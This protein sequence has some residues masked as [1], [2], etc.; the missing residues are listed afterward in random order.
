MFQTR[1][2]ISLFI[3][4][5]V[6]LLLLNGCTSLGSGNVPTDRFNYN[7]AIAKSRN[8]QML[9]NI[10]RAR[11]LDIPDFL[12]VSSVIT[13][14]SYEG[15]LGV[16]GTTG[17]LAATDNIY[18]GNINLGYAAKPTISYAP[19]SGQEFNRRMVKEIP[20]E[21]LF[22]LGHAGWPMDILM[23]ISISRINHIQNMGFSQVPAPG[24]VP[25]AEKLPYE[26]QH[27]ENFQSLL[28]LILRLEESGAMEVQRNLKDGAYQTYLH[29]HSN[30]SP[31]LQPMIRKFK[32]QLELDET[33]NN[34]RITGRITDI[35][36]D[37]ITMQS[38]SLLAIISYL[39]HGIEVPEEDSNRGLVVQL[40]PELQNAMFRRLPLRVYSQKEKPEDPYVAVRYRGYWFYIDHSDIRSKRTFSTVQVL[41]QLQAPSAASAAPVLTLPTGQ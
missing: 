11:Y 36:K 37:E 14:Y 33:K 22:S 2:P 26:L 1:S 40:K 5:V 24:G 3:T 31:E 27:L 32:Q 7:A 21:A 20:I 38:R 18:T 8:E 12:A 35:G 4:T 34:F 16:S 13:T 30:P 39:S 17:G 6:S 25:G 41:F 28:L 10:I 9:L 29:F 23:Q 19:L 15:K